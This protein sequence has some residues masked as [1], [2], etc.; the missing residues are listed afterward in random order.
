[1]NRLLTTK[2]LNIEIIYKG[3]TE[4]LVDVERCIDRLGKGKVAKPLGSRKF[5]QFF[6]F[7]RV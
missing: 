2:R 3:V 5:I 6:G 1:M 7:L 4:N